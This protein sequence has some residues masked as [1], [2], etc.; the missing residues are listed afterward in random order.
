M[1][2]KHLVKISTSVQPYVLAV[3]PTWDNIS[4]SHVI[5]DKVL[6][7][8]KN[9]VEAVELCFKLF[10]VFHSDY[11]PESKHVWQLIQQGFYNI[12]LED[13]DIN[14]GTITKALADIGIYV[15]EKEISLTT[16]KPRNL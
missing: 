3:G 5:V 10:H 1:D 7:T 8:C 9:I 4:H 16:K 2:L 14:R 11:P 12:F 15:Q 6:Y 13:H